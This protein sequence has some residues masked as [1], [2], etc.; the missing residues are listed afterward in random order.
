MP[1]PGTLGDLR[2]DT[3]QQGLFGPGRIVLGQLADGVEE[4]RAPIVVEI[5][6]GNGEGPPGEPLIQVGP[7]RCMGKDSRIGLAYGQ[8]SR[9]TLGPPV[10]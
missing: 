1:G 2:R 4:S 3:V 9:A 6:A 8:L 7:V 10:E 5:F